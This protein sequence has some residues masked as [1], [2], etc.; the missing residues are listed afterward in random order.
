VLSG[1]TN[2]ILV[3]RYQPYAGGSGP[4]QLNNG[5]DFNFTFRVGV[6]D[7]MEDVNL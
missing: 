7:L 3:N 5:N 4:V 6:S 2:N 1:F